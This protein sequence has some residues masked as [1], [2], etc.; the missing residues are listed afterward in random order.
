MQTEK[1]VS[2]ILWYQGFGFLAII[3]LTWAIKFFD[4]LGYFGANDADS[5]N[6]RESILDTTLVVMVAIPVL[7]LTKRLVSHLYY[8]EGLLHICAWCKKLQDDDKWVPLEDFFQEN[9][10]MRTS[11]G[12]CMTCAEH[13]KGQIRNRAGTR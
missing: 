6:W 9:F 3:A 10:H 1:Y 8:L 7:I 5:V 2:R 11:H 13:M 4:L 12:M